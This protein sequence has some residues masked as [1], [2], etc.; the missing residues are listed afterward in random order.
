MRNDTGLLLLTAER[1]AINRTK[2]RVQ[3]PGG[4][5]R[6]TMAYNFKSSKFA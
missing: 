5:R 6:V 3:L 2:W 1:H 4:Q